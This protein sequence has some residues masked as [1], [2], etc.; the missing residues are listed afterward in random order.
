[1]WELY[2]KWM[3]GLVCLFA[4]GALASCQSE[5]R[6][7]LA[8][9]RKVTA[10]FATP[11]LVAPP[12]KIDDILNVLESPRAADDVLLTK[13]K[14]QA[15][16]KIS[17]E[18]D[19]T[20][21]AEAYF[22][23]AMAARELGR[24]NQEISD[25]T[26]SVALFQAAGDANRTTSVSYAL[27]LAEVK[28]GNFE[29]G[30][31]RINRAVEQWERNE[32]STNNLPSRPELMGIFAQSG[33]F[34]KAD[35]LLAETEEVLP[36]IDYI[37]DFTELERASVFVALTQGKADVLTWKGQLKEAEKSYRSAIR[38]WVDARNLFDQGRKTAGDPASNRWDRVLN[39]LI[40]RLG[41]NLRKQGRFV[42]AEIEA[43][44]AL[45]GTLRS[46]GKYSSETASVLRALTW[47]I[48]EQGRYSEAE[49]LSRQNLEIFRRVGASPAAINFGLARLLYGDA[50]IAQNK[51]EQAKLEFARLRADFSNDPAALSRIL[52]GNLN[53]ASVL[54]RDNKPLQ[55]RNFL[56]EAL[57]LS[58]RVRG[59]ADMETNE[60]RGFL[61][62]TYVQTSE[63]EKALEL[64]RRSVPQLI[65]DYLER[66]FSRSGS[67]LHD[68][69]FVRIAES[70]IDL[71]FEMR[72]KDLASSTGQEFAAESF[73]LADIVR[74][75]TV[76]QAL[77]ASSSRAAAG[78][79]AL[80]NLVRRTQD[81]KAQIES[82]ELIISSLMTS[83]SNKTMA[84][85]IDVQHRRLQTLRK[86]RF[87]LLTEVTNKFPKYADLMNPRP[88]TISDVQKLLQANE[89]LIS[90][91]VGEKRTYIWAVPKSGAIAFSSAA[92]GRS[93]VGRLVSK[94]RRALA[95]PN[96]Q[97][98]GD[99]PAF[100]LDTAHQLYRQ[101]LQP[102]KSGWGRATNIAIVSH[103]AL[104]Q[105]PL[106]L[107]VTAP[108]FTHTK[109]R[110]LFARYKDVPWLIRSHNI[111]VL[112]SV[113]S[114]ASLRKFPV[115][116]YKQRAF[117]GFAD[118]YFN[119]SQAAAASRR[120]HAISVA[121]REA[122]D[123][124]NLPMRLRAGPTTH[125]M[126]SA[127]LAK[128][129]RLPDTAEE[130]RSIAIATKANLRRDV[131]TGYRA[132]EER[133]KSIN[134]SQYRIVAFATHGLV[135]G[136]LDGL[137]QPALAL[138]APSV[139]GSTGDGLLT[140]GEILNLKMNA[141]W[142]VLSACNTGAAN[143]AGAEA[144]SGLGRAFFFAG[145][146]A[147]LLSNW[148]VESSS[149]RLLTT[150]LFRSS[151]R[152]QSWSRARALRHAMLNLIDG[153]GY[154]DNDGR[155]VF[156]YAH[157]I[158]WAPFSLVGDG[159]GG[160]PAG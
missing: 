151:A 120:N 23:R 89:A 159:G 15:D 155:T 93:D 1:M 97:S 61:A 14:N 73:R 36:S 16:K 91:F 98:L 130:I 157:P 121:G 125:Q 52:I 102:V 85:N 110:Q 70:Y 45:R 2:I 138:S 96:V 118:P 79:A 8:E 115:S 9:A 76:Q 78:N 113:A 53:W 3:R 77:A 137:S 21:Q 34:S 33:D 123:I 29:R 131:F 55:A 24:A 43:R 41:D 94:L 71:L 158:F 99:I 32:Q 150:E 46:N 47:S 58:T 12:R 69:R 139:T 90:I 39:L 13:F 81:T 63:Q 122:V 65:E 75:R 160:K 72:N 4:V 104:G 6:L 147:L 86:A 153:P 38:R 95:P 26:Q 126:S 100:D 37:E 117:V 119:H 128:L 88:I 31:E 44:K 124:R 135:P 149:A 83:G 156:S 82:T 35:E 66:R 59:E 5:E 48:Y 112:P 68:R 140:M 143:G 132:T 129:P 116:R 54:M 144:F 20:I 106:S 17:A 7:T 133:V 127:E 141:E 51:W 49:A 10:N 136:D 27:G 74:S 108:T 25:L 50:L 57:R 142:V 92:L 111:S 103:G 87:A 40:T 80:A 64:F 109:G 154:V 11:L 105:L 134:L 56:A 62:A 152:N 114:L 146:R 42:E 107:L 22:A 19:L 18:Q 101:L 67:S 145:A 60:I 30:L 28:A 148:P 84:R